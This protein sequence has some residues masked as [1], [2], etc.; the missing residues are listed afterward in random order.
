[1][2][3]GGA[4]GMLEMHKESTYNFAQNEANCGVLGMPPRS[5]LSR[6]LDEAVALKDMARSI[7]SKVSSMGARS[8]RI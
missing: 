6:W 7:L 1:M 4:A 8:N 5:N 3:K 2:G